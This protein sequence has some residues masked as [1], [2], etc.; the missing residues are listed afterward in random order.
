MNTPKM[1]DLWP[2]THWSLVGQA[3]EG[4][5][6]QRAKALETLI[7]QYL[8]V[9]R[10]HLLVVL[11]I[12]FKEVDDA[13]QDFMLVKVLQKE[14]IT[15]ADQNRGRFRNFLIVTINRFI[16]NRTRDLDAKL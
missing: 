14:L 7:K 6:I 16:R 12:S 15:L 1:K 2:T 11:R 13:L 4:E 3:G 10:R 8:P 9:L 5:E